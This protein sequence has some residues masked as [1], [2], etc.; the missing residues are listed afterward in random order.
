[1]RVGGVLQG[2]LQTAYP[3]EVEGSDCKSLVQIGKGTPVYLKLG[4]FNFEAVKLALADHTQRLVKVPPSV[5]HSYIRALRFEGGLLGGQ[6]FALSSGLN[7]LI[8][9]RGSGKSSVL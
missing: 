5:A 4:D 6:R 2:R 8:G 3:A 9:I 7:C 1:M